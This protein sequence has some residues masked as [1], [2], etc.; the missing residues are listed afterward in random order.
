MHLYTWIYMG[1]L[2]SLILGCTLIRYIF[3]LI[4]NHIFFM[5]VVTSITVTCIAACM[6]VHTVHDSSYAYF[7]C[8]HML[9]TLINYICVYLVKKVAVLVFAYA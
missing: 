9:H 5:S 7:K 6:S 4:T 8:K 3:H 2:Y 1:V